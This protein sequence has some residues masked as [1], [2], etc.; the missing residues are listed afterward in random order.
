MTAIRA[1]AKERF[2]AKIMPIPHCGC[3]IFMGGGDKYYGHF[4]MVGNPVAAHRAAWLLFRGAIPPG[5]CV[6]HK[7]D[8]GYCVNPDHLFL[9]TQLDNARDREA[10]GRGNQ[11][12]GQRNGRHTKPWRTSRGDRHYTRLN[13]G[14]KRGELNGRAKLTATDVVT[15]RADV[16]SNGIIAR[17]R[18]LT[19]TTIRSIKL[20]RLWSHVP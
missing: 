14:C 9:G 20:R 12:I 18:G 13:P 16:R 2:E 8:V 15:I 11:Q 19:K 5:L 3:W 1:A 4:R 7:C 6:L 17:E 10:K